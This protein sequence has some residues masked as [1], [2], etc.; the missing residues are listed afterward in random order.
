[1]IRHRP[2]SRP[3]RTVAAAV[4]SVLA[5]ITLAACGGDPPRELAGFVREPGPTV[6][7]VALPDLS[8]GGDEFAMRA[9]PGELL[10]VYFGFTNCPDVCPTTL[11][12]LRAALRQMDPADAAR[13]QFAMVT[14][15]P[16]RDSPVLVDYAQTFVD[17][18]RALATDDPALL[19]AAADPFGVSYAIE[20]DD[21]GNIEVGHTSQMFVVDDRGELALTW[22]FGIPAADI[23][24]DL[25]QLLAER[26]A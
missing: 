20:T 9:D 23:A 18:A 16:D 1:M 17:D 26:S 11:A 12:D 10:V 4:T 22:Q 8:R 24:A 2:R 14:V 15:D 6:D 25:E 13:V 3:V 21:D 5:M 7:E 19:R